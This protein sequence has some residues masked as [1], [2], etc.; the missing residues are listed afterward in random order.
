MKTGQIRKKTASFALRKHS[1]LAG[2]SEQ[3]Q[4]IVSFS[5]PKRS[6]RLCNDACYATQFLTLRPLQAPAASPLRGFSF[7][8][9]QHVAQHVV[10]CFFTFQHYSC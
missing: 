8:P 10:C 1:I 9:I 3:T 6:F 5:A 4:D 2:T 7:I